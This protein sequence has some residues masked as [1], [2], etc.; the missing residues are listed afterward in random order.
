VVP[1]EDL[2]VR[3]EAVPLGRVIEI[4]AQ[5]LLNDDPHAPRRAMVNLRDV[6]VD[7]Q[8]RDAL[9]SFAG[10]IA[11]DLFNPL[12]VVDGWTEAL[13]D[14]FR[15][16]PVSPM[17]GSAIVARI[18][19]AAQ[20]MR[21]FIA[22]LMS[23]TIARDQSLRYGPVDVTAMV[24]SL[25]ALRSN[26]AVDP[27][28]VVG[29]GLY[30]WADSGLVRQLLDNLIGNAIKYVAP[31]VRPMVEITGHVD[32]DWLEVRVADNGIGI[33]EGEREAV[34]ESLHRA[35]AD[36]FGGTGLGLAICRR[37]VDRHGGTIKVEPVSHGTGSVFSFRL[38]RVAEPSEA[39]G[40]AVLPPLSA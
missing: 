39:G 13:A 30:A 7:R 38:P 35:H 5:P 12:T 27:L 20:H 34:F 36:R 6:T 10:V 8:H 1:P 32:G 4:S 9:A 19:D 25:A 14:E 11:H 37:I 18:S 17:V 23:Y 22:D 16:G 3:T 21:M 40:L 29:E 31:G 2:H 28:V 15:A 26:T 33:P 24:R